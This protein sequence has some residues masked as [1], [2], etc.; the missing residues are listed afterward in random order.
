[1]ACVGAL[2]RWRRTTGGR[3]DLP[4]DWSPFVP[5]DESVLASVLPKT[6]GRRRRSERTRQVIIDAYLQL[7]RRNLVM[8]TASQIAEE[9]GCSPRSVFERFSDLDTLNLATADYAIAQGRAEAAACDVRTDRA[10]RIRSHVRA[11][12]Q[13]CEKW[14]PL[15]RVLVNQDQPA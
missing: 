3:S 15:W 6:D 8:P 7:V 4:G 12:A 10:S 1:K 11:R 13:A 5:S 14:L 2:D 9:A